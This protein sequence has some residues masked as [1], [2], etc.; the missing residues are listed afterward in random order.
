MTL[1]RDQGQA[2]K[3]VG[4]LLL[5]FAC[6]DLMGVLVRV[7]SARYS[8]LELSAYRN[9]LGIIPSLAL[10][11][12][13]GELRL[14][15]TN[16]KI[17]K[18][19]LAVFRGLVVA[20]AQVLFYGALAVLELATVSALAQTNALFVVILS[21]LL[22][23]ERVGPWRMAALAIGFGGALWIMRPGSEAFSPYALLPVFAALCYAYSMISVR[24]FGPGTSNALLYL[25]ASGAAAVG[26]IVLALFTTD[27]SPIQG[28]LDAWLIFVMATLGGSGVLFMML[29]YRMGEPSMLAPFGY[30]GLITAFVFGW[31]FFGEAP[32]DT[33]FPGV[34]LIVGAGV[35]IIWREQR[36]SR[37]VP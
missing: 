19:P 35:L 8:P 18:W 17:E 27:F 7:L 32:V 31:V 15:G 10:L 13:T 6:F 37:K 25:Y 24:F 30:F 3:A 9:V 14:R 1:A 2:V 28:W 16:L 22:L 29:A 12:A 33:L 20:V 26:A 4:L 21:V 34:L 36:G 11:M 5:A 23:G